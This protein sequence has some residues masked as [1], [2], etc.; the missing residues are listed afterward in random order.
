M[1][2]WTPEPWERSGGNIWAGGEAGGNICQ[3]GE[4][5]VSTLVSHT[6]LG[7]RSP[8]WDEAQANGDRIIAAVNA[9]ASIS[10]EALAQGYVK[11]MV[12]V[13][14]LIVS[15]GKRHPWTGLGDSKGYGVDLQA[16]LEAALAQPGKKV[17]KK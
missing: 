7:L 3:I 4:P 13:C 5:R 1:A 2:K 12:R 6:P 14:K 17:V 15:F 10:T 9:C 8:D 11:E 16:A